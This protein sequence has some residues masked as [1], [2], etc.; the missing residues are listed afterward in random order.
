MSS[1]IRERGT[2]K[3][4]AASGTFTHSRRSRSIVGHLSSCFSLLKTY[5]FSQWHPQKG[6]VCGAT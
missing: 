4:S 3:Y 1:Y 5:I 2:P 6:P